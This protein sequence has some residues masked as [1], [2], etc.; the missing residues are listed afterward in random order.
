[1]RLAVLVTK[2]ISVLFR[3]VALQDRVRAVCV[4]SSF[5]RYVGTHLPL[6]HQ[7]LLFFLIVALQQHHY[8][9]M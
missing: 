2:A 1:M 5:C 4:D 7:S 9:R 6:P 3:N 8:V